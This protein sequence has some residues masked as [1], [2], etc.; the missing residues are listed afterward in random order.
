MSDINITTRDLTIILATTIPSVLIL[1]CLF[2]LLCCRA[3]RRRARMFKR[4]ITPIDDDEIESW[5][6]DRESEKRFTGGQRTSQ[7]TSHRTTLSNGSV[8]KPPSVIVYTPTQYA[9]RISDD[10][11]SLSPSPKFK[12]SI[13][14]P[15][16]P[17]TARAPNARPGLTDETIQGDDAYIS[18]AKRQPSRL[19]KHPPVSSRHHRA[20]STRTAAV[21]D[22]HNQW[23]GLEL[24]NQTP[25]R[26]STETFTRARSLHS[27][28]RGAFSSSP[29]NP[30][31][32]ISFDDDLLLGGLSPRPPVHQSEIGRAIG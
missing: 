24:D 8:R 12:R 32:R 13:D 26:K 15:T 21:G 23:Y 30:P 19:A 4:G 17:M 18:Q 22:L 7:R 25:S 27:S 11:H 29:I 1:A 9:N 20:W 16:T 3:R 5:K 28:S 6:L 14:L 2:A 31:P 10:H